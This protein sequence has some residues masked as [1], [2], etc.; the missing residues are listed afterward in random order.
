MKRV[1]IIHGW[2]GHPNEHWIPWLKR[3]LEK[4]GFAVE[5]PQM[6]NTESPKIEK[7]VPFLA[8]LV[9][10]PDKDTFF[11]GHSIG[12]QAVMRY[13]E[14]AKEPVGGVVFVAGWVTLKGLETPEEELVA[15]P[16]LETPIDFGK[17]KKSAGKIAAFFSDDDPFVPLDDAK[18]FRDKLGA[19]I[20]IEK[21]KGHYTMETKVREVPAVLEALLK[22]PIR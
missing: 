10:K 9:G 21:K 15:K 17:V 13:L 22:M 8:K 11:V 18:V 16:W 20:V 4:R 1:F 6:P 7:W 14:K 19:E 5:A 12:C 3:E 2:D